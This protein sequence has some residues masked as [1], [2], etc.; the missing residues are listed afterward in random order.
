MKSLQAL[1][2]ALREQMHS[3]IAV[4]AATAEGKHTL[5]AVVTDDLRDRGVRADTVIKE[6]AAIAGGRGG[7]KQ[8]M[9]QAG[10]PDPARIPEALGRLPDIVRGLLGAV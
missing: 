6:L 8:H 3:G 10:I 4:L 5:L 9:A 2:D 1:G 7:G